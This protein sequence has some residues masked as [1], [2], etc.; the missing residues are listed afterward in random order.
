MDASAPAIPVID[1]VA[2]LARR[3]DA[4]LCDIWGVMHNGERAHGE[5]A[6]A[7]RRFRA[8]GGAVVLISNSPRPAPN[9]V[10]QLDRFG[11]PREAYDSV[12]TSG[13]VTRALVRDRPGARVFHLGPDRDRPIF[14]GL[15]VALVGPEEAEIVVCSGLVNDATETPDD[16]AALLAAL[17]A[18]A[19]PMICANPDLKVERGERLVYCAGAL[20]EA[21]AAMGG[22]VTH[23]GKPHRPLYEL[24]FR[25]LA[26]HLGRPVDR[27]RVL[28]IGDGLKTDMA[29]AAANGLDALF[30]ASALHLDAGARQRRLDEAQVAALFEGEPSPPIAAMDGLKW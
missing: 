23:A 26:E 21:Y 24:A 2:D 5:A 29:G 4:W 15:D 20:A 28:A 14:E 11:V 16:Y 17:R 8:Q 13:D 7:C 25:R 3:Y 18:R 22:T 6:E 1:S 9:V 27:R 19:L 10:R 12:A 30:I